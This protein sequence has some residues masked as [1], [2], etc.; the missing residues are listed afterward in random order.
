M[1]QR[2]RLSFFITKHVIFTVFGHREIH[3][4][5]AKRKR[6]TL[7]MHGFQNFKKVY[8]SKKKSLETEGMR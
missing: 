4:L 7:G 8:I 1:T 2:Y 6:I 5:K 3:S